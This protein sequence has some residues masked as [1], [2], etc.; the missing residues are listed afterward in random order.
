MFIWTLIT[1]LRSCGSGFSTE[2]WL[3]IPPFYTVFFRKM[4][5]VT[6][7]MYAQGVKLHLLE[8]RALHKLFGILLWEIGLFLLFI[9]S[10]T[11]L[12]ISVWTHWYLFYT[13]AS[14]PVLFKLLCCSNWIQGVLISERLGCW[15]VLAQERTSQPGDRV[16][17]RGGMELLVLGGF[18][19][20][21]CCSGSRQLLL[22][23]FGG[24]RRSRGTL[25]PT[26]FE[27]LEKN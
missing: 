20:V 8:S 12:F 11:P 10:C 7:H 27:E 23:T 4:S 19:C 1:W 6:T 3:F 15:M 22:M 5:L 26:P 14:N 21:L 13:L 2:K 16:G 18:H 17:C 25:P 9:D 24:G